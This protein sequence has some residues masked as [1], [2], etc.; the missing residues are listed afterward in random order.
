MNFV[1]GGLVF[2]SSDATTRADFGNRDEADLLHLSELV[3]HAALRLASFFRESGNAWENLAT[4]VIGKV[5]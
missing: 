1:F 5:S 3:L 2:F 4:L